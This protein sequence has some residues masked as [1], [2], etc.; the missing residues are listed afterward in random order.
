MT[1][2]VKQGLS[3]GVVVALVVSVVVGV[4]SE[5]FWMFLATLGFSISCV[6]AAAWLLGRT[7]P[8]AR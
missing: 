1:A 8:K 6:C 3:A 4:T 5:S 7:K 2:D